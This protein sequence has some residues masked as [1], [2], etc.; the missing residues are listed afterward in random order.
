MKS[1]PVTVLAL[2]WRR[3]CPARTRTLVSTQFRILRMST[4]TTMLTELVQLFSANIPIGED[5][6]LADDAIDRAGFAEK[7]N[8]FPQLLRAGINNSGMLSYQAP[9]ALSAAIPPSSLDLVFSEG[10]L[11]HLEPLDEAY[12][13]MF[14]WLKHGG[15]SSHGLD[16]V[17][18]SSRRI[19]T[20]IGHTPTGSG[21][22]CGGDGLSC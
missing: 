21:G 10:V 19:G 3:Y 8:A 15:Y 20:A 11:Q 17:E 5:T 16:S 4:W 1:V 12:R 22:W 13:M 9:W 14:G 7:V 2:A 18:A 6:P